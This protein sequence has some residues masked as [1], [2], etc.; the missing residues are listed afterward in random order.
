MK[1]VNKKVLQAVERLTRHEVEKM[2]AIWPPFCA[3]IY[4][5]PKRPVQKKEK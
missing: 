3:G 4:H 5:Q 1:K 2:T